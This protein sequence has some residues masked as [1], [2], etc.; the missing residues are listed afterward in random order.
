MEEE[1]ELGGSRGLEGVMESPIAKSIPLCSPPIMSL[2]FLHAFR[3]KNTKKI[4]MHLSQKSA[5]NSLKASNL[6]DSIAP[7]PTEK[8]LLLDL[9]P[10]RSRL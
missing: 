9:S 6:T 2:E 3:S 7:L 8:D 10:S 4:Y 5:V 1:A